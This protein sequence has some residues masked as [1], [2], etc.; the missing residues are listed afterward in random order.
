[1]AIDKGAQL[2][3]IRMQALDKRI[4]QN[5]AAALSSAIQQQQAAIRQLA[6]FDASKFPDMTAEQMQAQRIVYVNRI[7]KQTNVVRA[8]ASE[9]AQGG[10][11]AARVIQSEMLNVFGINLDWAEYSIDRQAGLLMNW[12][13]YDQRQLQ[14]LLEDG[15]S[16]FT[17][18][19]YDN[20]GKEQPIVNKLKNELTQAVMLGE[21]QGE[22][23]K[24]IRNVTGQSISQA[25]RVAQTERNRVQSQA[26][27]MGMQEAEQMGI[28]MGKRWLSRMDSRVR[29]VHAAVTGEEVANEDTFSNGLMYPGDP[30]GAAYQIVNCRCV[31][32]PMVLNVP[33]SVKAYRAQMRKSYGFDEWRAS[34]A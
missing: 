2:T 5:Y 33:N 20:L 26:R 15:A 34:R 28:D 16:P 19:A 21:S 22:L 3:D 12:Q 30:A 13:I 17:R 9:I 8:L 23:I 27:F 24:R 1:M 14:V 10:Q 7:D 6:A 4:Q 31:L 18:I 29:D 11:G 25:R 32:Q